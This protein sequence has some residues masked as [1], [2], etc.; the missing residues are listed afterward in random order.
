[1]SE[2]VSVALIAVL[3]TLGSGT[4]AYL[5]S[6]K[7]SKVQLEGL[8][9]EMKK[10]HET[11]EEENR[12]N[13]AAVYTEYLVAVLGLEWF[14]RGLDGSDNQEGYRQA[15][16]RI[17]RAHSDVAL[18]G[19]SEAEEAA[20]ALYLTISKFLSTVVEVGKKEPKLD[21]VECQ[22]KALDETAS[23]RH[24]ARH[25]FRLAA[26]ADVLRQTEADS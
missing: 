7:S 16:Q 23:E 26:R 13:R 10:L 8:R 18:F 22:R 11:H 19:S 24:A 20:S 12:Q 21:V 5:A 2:T 1:M 15:L 6:S 3:G 17:Q 9:V 25:A 14:A 4:L